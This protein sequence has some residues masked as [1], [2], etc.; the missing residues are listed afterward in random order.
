MLCFNMFLSCVIIALLVVI[1]YT[2]NHKSQ[3]TNKSHYQRNKLD[4][5]DIKEVL[6]GI[7]AYFLL[8]FP[9]CRLCSTTTEQWTT[10]ADAATT[11]NETKKKKEERHKN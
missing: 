4:I 2:F 6:C 7:A 8:A 3:Q 11:R 5:K 10:T 1:F 9:S